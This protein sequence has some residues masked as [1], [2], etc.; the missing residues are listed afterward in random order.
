MTA[1]FEKTGAT[2]GTLTFSINQ[3]LQKK[4]LDAAFNKQ[5]GKITVPGFRKGKITREMFNRM[6]G[7]EALYQ[8]AVNEVLEEAFVAA[9]T[10]TGV[11]SVA[12]PQIDIKSMDKG[13]DW[14]LTAVVT[15]KPE[16]KLGEYKKLEVSVEVNKEVTDA[17]IEARLTAAQSRMAE[18]ALKEGAAEN[19]DTVVIDFAG[20]VDGVEFD[21]GK[22]SNYS[23]E[24]GSGSFIPGFEDQLIGSKAGDEV[25][26]KV[27]FPED[28]QAKDLAGKDAIFATTIHEVKAKEIPAL[29]DEL[30][31]DI[32]DSVETL[33]EL[34]AKYKEEITANKE[35][36]YNEAVEAAAIEAAVAN[37]TIDDIPEPMLHDEIHRAMN[38]FL[39]G[40]QQQGI[41]PEMYYQITGTTE[42]QMHDQYA[43]EAETR[44]KTNLV[45]EEI[46]K[47]E[48]FTVAADEIEAEVAELAGQYNMPLDQIKQLLPTAMLEHDIKMKKAVD[49]ITESVKVK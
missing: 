45:I 28:Y 37:A 4:G 1:T 44:V 40:M 24:L 5:K 3:D 25:E 39:G 23:L 30:A 34:K 29:D 13:A 49:V 31:K 8:D 48:N 15:T 7:E 33:D 38:E 42:Q 9:L 46:A 20:S 17:D 27:T 21:G 26:V 36:A 11:E 16:V 35:E 32:D 41:S 43:Q 22:G 19:G 10:E 2:T 18:L 14:E 6:F 12:Q 47:V